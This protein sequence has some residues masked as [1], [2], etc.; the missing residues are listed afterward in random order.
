MGNKMNGSF[1]ALEWVWL[2][3]VFWQTDGNLQD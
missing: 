1:G 2:K 3:L